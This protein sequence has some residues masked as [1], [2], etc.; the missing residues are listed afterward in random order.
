[1]YYYIIE[2]IFIVILNNMPI[3]KCNR[4]RDTG[5]YDLKNK[6]KWPKNSKK[7]KSLNEQNIY[8]NY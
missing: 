2:Y 7:K 3:D 8:L 4:Y 1:M 6:Q 5:C